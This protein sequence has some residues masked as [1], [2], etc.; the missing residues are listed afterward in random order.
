MA[1]TTGTG[2]QNQSAVVDA[3]R[4][5]LAADGWT[6]VRNIG[7][8]GANDI[9]VIMH[10]P[11]ADT[12]NGLDILVGFNSLPSSPFEDPGD[13]L[14]MYISYFTPTQAG[15]NDSPLRDMDRLMGAPNIIYSLSSADT[16]RPSGNVGDV[17]P[18]GTVLTSNVDAKPSRSDGWNT[19]ANYLNHWIFTP[20]SSPLGTEEQYCYVVV[21]V[22]TGVYRSFGFGEAILLGGAQGGIFANSSYHDSADDIYE[23][24]PY[25]ADHEYTTFSNDGEHGWILDLQNENY[26]AKS[27]ATWNPWLAFGGPWST[28][29]VTA[30]GMG[31]RALGA[32]MIN[33]TPAPFSGQTQRVPARLYAMANIINGTEAV[34]GSPS[35]RDNNFR[36]FAEIP[37]IFHTN[38]SDLTPGGTVT[39]D[40]ESFL[41]VP[42]KNKTGTDNTGNYGYL[43]RHP[44]L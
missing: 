38:I 12:K 19:G 40:G 37:H 9:E 36:P 20:N 22:A 28:D 21:E 7:S 13:M 32:E 18:N 34:L 43:I 41:V 44:S 24:H 3:V 35:V 17:Y 2:L 6:T 25:A 30:L 10:L 23:N 5:H 42:Y 39:D 27:P 16:A 4:T 14:D 33:N 11:A 8:I 1:L 15:A 26:L 29:W 31:P